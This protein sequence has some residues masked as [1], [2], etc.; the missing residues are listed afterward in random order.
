MDANDVIRDAVCGIYK[1][2]VN[3]LRKIMMVFRRL[4][5]LPSISRNRALLILTLLFL[6]VWFL[7]IKSLPKKKATFPLGQPKVG[8]VVNFTENAIFKL[9][10]YDASLAEMPFDDAEN[11]RKNETGDKMQQSKNKQ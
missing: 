7:L 11:G 2:D 9:V 1:V 3:L 8:K 6:T 5:N 4:L 10:H